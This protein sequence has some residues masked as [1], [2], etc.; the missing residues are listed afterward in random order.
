MKV[1]LYDLYFDFL[2]KSGKVKL[3]PYG[4]RIPKLSISNYHHGHKHF[5]TNFDPDKQQILQDTDFQR[6]IYFADGTTNVP[7]DEPYCGFQG[8]KCKEKGKWVYIRYNGI[9]SVVS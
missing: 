7:I 5:I 6:S 8:S 9:Y 3:D 2:G 1:G 4:D